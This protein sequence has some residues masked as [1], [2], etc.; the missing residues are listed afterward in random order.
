MNIPA[1]TTA[2]RIS[3]NYS[4]CHK[5]DRMVLYALQS[6]ENLGILQINY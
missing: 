1:V 4:L 5:D 3:Y 6:R 2:V